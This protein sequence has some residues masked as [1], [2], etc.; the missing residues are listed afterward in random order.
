MEGVQLSLADQ[1]ATK[2]L[3]YGVIVS[4]Y[5]RFATWR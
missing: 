5:F 4:Y 2:F 1:E 3:Y